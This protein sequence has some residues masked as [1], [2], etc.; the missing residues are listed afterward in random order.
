MINKAVSL[1]F[2]IMYVFFYEPAKI[3]I[4]SFFAF[5]IYACRIVHIS[6]FA[7]L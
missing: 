4:Y 1:I 7:F 5:I 2:V 6:D 3:V